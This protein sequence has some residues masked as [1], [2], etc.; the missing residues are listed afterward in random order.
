VA[1]YE[2]TDMRNM[3]KNDKSVNGNMYSMYVFGDLV[4]V[5]RS[6][7][8]IRELE[9][10]EPFAGKEEQNKGN[11]RRKAHKDKRKGLYD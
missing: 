8:S 9:C 7:L 10:I 2:K 1:F 6:R 11:Q 4:I 5:Q 3:N